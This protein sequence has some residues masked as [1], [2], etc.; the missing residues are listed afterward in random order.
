MIFKL[1][2]TYFKSLY[3][4]L[5]I[6]SKNLFYPQRNHM[7]LNNK[8]IIYMQECCKRELVK[9]KKKLFKINFF[10][11]LNYFGV[12]ISKIFFKLKILF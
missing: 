2:K 5:F 11:F 8:S 9:F 10:M 3:I 1:K 4:Y 6:Y 7:D 12:V